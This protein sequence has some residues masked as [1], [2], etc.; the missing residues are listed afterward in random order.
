MRGGGAAAAAGHGV[1]GATLQP[2]THP[3][4]AS[5]VILQLLSNSPHTGP[6]LI[7]TAIH[8][9]GEKFSGSFLEERWAAGGGGGKTGDF[10]F[11]NIKKNLK[12]EI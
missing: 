1:G 9:P 7:P 12:N 4:T 8:L 3:T 10:L 11:R 5:L 6:F 2:P